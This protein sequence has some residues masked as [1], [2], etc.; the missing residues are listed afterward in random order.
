MVRDVFWQ[1]CGIRWIESRGA[2]PLKYVVYVGLNV[3]RHVL[4]ISG[5]R[6]IESRGMCPGKY[7][8]YVGLKLRHVF[9]QIS[10]IRWIE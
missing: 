7:V 10:S 6:W 5:I 4:T 8:V 3:D 1:I 2:C 9:W